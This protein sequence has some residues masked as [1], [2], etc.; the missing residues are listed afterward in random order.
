MSAVITSSLNKLSPLGIA[1]VI[2]LMRHCSTV[3]FIW[4]SPGIAKSSV[5]KQVAT[6]MGIAFIDVRLAMY[7]PTDV[8][9]MPYRVEEN[10]V[11]VGVEFTPPKILPRDINH[12]SVRIIEA[13]DTTVDFSKLNPTG[14]NGIHYVREPKVE[15]TAINDIDAIEQMIRVI[16]LDRSL[17]AEN[18]DA[19]I[20]P[21]DLKLTA[22]LV[23]HTKTEF[24]AHLVDRHG[25]IRAGKLQYHITGE[26]HGLVAME[27]LNVAP[28]ATQNA[29]YQFILDRRSG[30]YLVPDG[31]S[32]IAMG[33]RDTDG[34]HT[35]KMPPA[36]RNRFDHIEM[37]MKFEDWQE[38]AIYSRVHPLV[39]GYL[40]D[41]KGAALNLF[42][43]S[44]ADR[45]FCTPR[46]WVMVSDILWANERT[47][48]L[49]M[50]RDKDDNY[51]LAK[52]MSALI[53]GAI[54]EGEG[55]KFVKYC[56]QAKLLPATDDIM[57][58]KVKV[59]E[60]KNSA[61]AFTVVAMT[62]FALQ[63]GNDSL[64]ARGIDDKSND[65][66]RMK[67]YSHFDNCI[68]FWMT[69]FETEVNIMAVRSILTIQKLPVTRR[70]ALPNLVEFT[71]KYGKYIHMATSPR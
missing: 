54:G 18:I 53:T 65:E 46:S 26:A 59:L 27:E 43:K 22:V 67:W 41:T 9:G 51:I 28:P 56:Q 58:G 38:W 32:I 49:P 25:V 6:E 33:N 71:T 44:R 39:L 47:N 21:E 23:G 1:A 42:E 37:E 61:L 20:D 48:M 40:S 36:L 60:Q 10:G 31:V 29:A 30:D 15:V 62:C 34:G 45:A 3:P 70:E 2:R 68:K 19:P 14:A 11:T 5:A 57:S 55:N 16:K 35:I 63:E 8:L 64:I 17:R 12:R 24:T 52:E 7:A 66:D 13:T 50:F 69:N 4:G